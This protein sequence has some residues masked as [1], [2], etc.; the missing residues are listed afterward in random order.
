M[1]TESILPEIFNKKQPPD[2]KKTYS[3]YE[4]ASVQTIEFWPTA[5]S[6]EWPE[7]WVARSTPRMNRQEMYKGLEEL[8]TQYQKKHPT[9]GW[10]YPLGKDTHD[11]HLTH[12]SNAP[13]PYTIGIYL[14]LFEHKLKEFPA[15]EKI[16]SLNKDIGIL[17]H[18]GYVPKL[19][20]TVTRPILEKI[21][22][23]WPGKILYFNKSFR[24]ANNKKIAK[25]AKVIFSYGEVD[26]FKSTSK[27][28][29]GRLIEEEL[30][31]DKAEASRSIRPFIIDDEDT[32]SRE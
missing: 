20:N 31:N 12:H 6:G 2:S 30:P 16:K 25:T 5:F 13:T 1:T 4:D 26:Y 15:F 24:Y 21:N 23:F 7:P 17:V 27:N 9:T 28:R 11:L 10:M 19:K 8:I 22:R 18:L 32:S 29:M 14:N 3:V